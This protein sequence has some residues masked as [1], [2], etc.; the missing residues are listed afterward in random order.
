MLKKKGIQFLKSHFEHLFFFYSYLRAKLFYVIILSFSVCLLDALSLSMFIP[1]FEISTGSQNEKRSELS[2]YF[3]DFLDFFHIIPSINAVL[4]I[5]ILFFC[6]KAIL[7]YSDLYYRALVNSFFIRKLRL[8][9]VNLISNIKYSKFITT[10]LGTIQNSLTTEIVNVNSAYTHYISVIQN[11]IFIFVYI[12]MSFCINPRF[13]LIIMVG[14]IFSKFL[15]QKLYN[16]SKILSYSITNKNNILSSLLMQ[17]VNNFKYLKSTAKTEEFSKK[18]ENSIV[19]I[20]NEQIKIGKIG[21]RVL[22]IREPIVIVFLASAIFIQ[23]NV[24]KGTLTSVLPSLLFFYRAFNNLMTLQSSWNAFLKYI[25]SVQHIVEF[26]SKISKEIEIVNGEDFQGFESEISLK[27]VSFHFDNQV[28]V[29]DNI[30]LEIKKNQSVAIVGKSGSGKTTFVNLISGLLA[31]VS[32]HILIDKKDLKKINLPTFRKKIGFI[33]QE[34]VVFNDTIF[35]NITFWSEKNA[36]NLKKFYEVI[37]KVDLTDFLE[38]ST[39]KEDIILGDNGVVMSGGQR[40]R[41]SIARELFK[42]TEILIL[43]EATSSLDSQTEKLIQQSI[44]RISGSL[45]IIIIAH[46]LSTIKKV[47]TI[48]LFSNGKIE[49]S[50]N[51]EQLIQKS[52]VFS[53]MVDLQEI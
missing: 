42:D 19:D 11:L 23:V 2:Q 41:L 12:F 50:G 47:D 4:I 24:L 14:A 35:N 22:S 10:D 49:E 16:N 28:K 6:L 7:R 52:S 18:L 46:R 43:D 5:M 8:N 31:P 27:N 34:T 9:L 32:G 39:E 37:E 33:T 48:F 51:F 25:G 36:A 30:S 3:Q 1:L 53:K 13:T 40:Q 20:E 21:A 44:D 15:F 17:F 38:R 45:T 26:K 29:L